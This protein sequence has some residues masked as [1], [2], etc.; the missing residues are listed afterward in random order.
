MKSV[1][2]WCWHTPRPEILWRQGDCFPDARHLSKSTIIQ[3]FGKYQQHGTSQ[4]RNSGNS[5]RPRLVRNEQ[6]IE[7]FRQSI[8]DHPYQST[9]KNH[10]G[11]ARS[12]FS[13][14]VKTIKFHPTSSKLDK[15]LWKEIENVG[16]ISASGSFRYVLLTLFL[17]IAIV[18][19]WGRS[20]SLRLKETIF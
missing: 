16:S 10:L 6:G 3:N 7:V 13:C 2:S 15:H 19:A 17:A 12:A 18:F 5:G 8:E 1:H 14:L 20:F 11:I 4:N 9:R